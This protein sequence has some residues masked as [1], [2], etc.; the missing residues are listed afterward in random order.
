MID[1]SSTTKRVPKVPS[2]HLRERVSKGRLSLKED[3]FKGRLLYK[4]G[5]LLLEEDGFEGRLLFTSKRVS[6]RSTDHISQNKERV[7]H[8]PITSH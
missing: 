2:P 4:R 7:K 3:G 8:R 1:H 5:R 6:K